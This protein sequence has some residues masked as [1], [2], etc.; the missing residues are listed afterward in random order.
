MRE[1]YVR[2]LVG[3]EF[4][5]SEYTVKRNRSVD[6]AARTISVDIL[7]DE[8]TNL[9]GYREIRNQTYLIYDGETYVVGN[10]KEVTTGQT[11]KT[12][13]AEHIFYQK[14]KLRSRIYTT[15][16]GSRTPKELLDFILKDTGYTLVLDTT[17][18]PEKIDVEN[19]GNNNPLALLQDLITTKMQAEFD[20]SDTQ[21]F[22]A[23]EIGRVT[24][25]QFRHEFNIN[26]PSKEIDTT[27][28]RT[29]IKGFST[30][31]ADGSYY[32][33]A[34][35][36]S[37][38]AEV[39]GI[40]IAD[41]LYD[42]Q[43][44]S[45]ASLTEACKQALTDTIDFTIQLTAMQLEEMDLLDVQKGDYLWCIIDPFDID[46]RVR[47][48]DIEDYED[49]NKAPLFTLGKVKRKASA[50]IAD[51]REATKAVNAIYDTTTKKV[52]PTAIDGSKISVNLANA[53]GQVTPAQLPFSTA[54]S[55]QAG[56]MSAAD[57]TKLANLKTGSDGNV[58]VPLATALN[59]G[60][61]S[62]EAFQKLNLIAVNQNGQVIV[63]FSNAD[64]STNQTIKNIQERLTLLENSSSS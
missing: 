4:P 6:N 2:N 47:V 5:L 25:K 13:S 11:K 50:L 55:S 38:L 59:A 32:Y 42:D 19:F 29:Y 12:I 16:T 26:S 34:E 15:I 35:Y 53:S 52:K 54:N 56:L 58:M 21:I 43:Y 18:L 46:I 45:S 8:E 63:D 41:P 7:L 39:Y 28:L 23:S 10:V 22:V 51:F 37:P 17:N 49:E 14:M 24:D 62:A 48:V 36:T 9:Q 1:L 20:Y 64:L 3:E 31:N 30:Q 60:L 61:M 44:K 33:V 40:L 57:Y 27:N